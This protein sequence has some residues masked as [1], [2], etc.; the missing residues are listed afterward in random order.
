MDYNDITN[1]APISGASL[2]PVLDDLH[3]SLTS[4]PPAL[5]PVCNLITLPNELILEVVKHLGHGALFSLHLSCRSLYSLLVPHLNT[6]FQKN[7]QHIL[8]MAIHQHQPTTLT[9]ALS[10]GAA[11]TS[12][13]V[14]GAIREHPAFVAEMLAARPDFN[15]NTT[16]AGDYPLLHLAAIYGRAECVG[17]LLRAGADPDRM[18]HRGRPALFY[19]LRLDDADVVRA[20]V[21]DGA[22]R[23]TRGM[24]ED[25]M[26][27]AVGNRPAMVAPLAAAGW[28]GPR[29]SEGTAPLKEAVR[30]GSLDVARVL[31]EAGADVDVLDHGYNTMGWSSLHECVWQEGSGPMMDLLV[32]KG[33][34]LEVLGGVSLDGKPWG[35]PGKGKGVTPWQLA[36]LEGKHEAAARL[37]V[38]GARM[39]M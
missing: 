8:R 26:V 36:K 32:E 11:L 6:A 34:N 9:R 4:H 12:E 27:Y 3:S 23:A 19:A 5:L 33:A 1:P 22:S 21:A 15:V 37:Q 38:Y 31:L 2:L 10:A 18:C 20:L 28:A 39:W 7:V 29:M 16:T 30:G 35:I 14:R 25:P 13:D 17:V 24:M